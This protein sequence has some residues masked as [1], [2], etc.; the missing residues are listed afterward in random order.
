MQCT[1]SNGEPIILA[2]MNAPHSPSPL[3]SRRDGAARPDPR[4]HRSLQRRHES[5]EGQPRRRRLLRRQRQGAAARVRAARGKRAPEERPR[6]AAT[7]RSTAW[8][9]TTRRCRRWCS[10]TTAASG[11][12]HRHRAGARRHRRPARSAPTSSSVAQPGRRG[13]D[14]RPELGEP[15]RA[16]R[17]RRLHG[18]DLSVLRRRRRTASISPACC[19]ALEGAAGRRDRRAARLLPQP[20]RRRP[21]RRSNGSEVLEIVQRARPGARSSTSPTRASPTASTPTRYAARLFRRSAMS[22]VFVSSS[23]SKSFSLYGER[24]GALSVGHRERRR[25]GARAVAAEARRPHQLLQPADARRP[26]RRDRAR[27]AGAARAVGPASS[28]RMRER[29]KRDAPA[30]GRQDQDARAAARLRLRARSSA[31]CSPTR[32]SPRSRCAPARRILDLRHRHRPHL[33]RRA[34]HRATSTTSPTRSRRSSASYLQP[35]LRSNCP[36]S[37]RPIEVPIPGSSAVPMAALR[38]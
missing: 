10:A 23:F 36:P 1:V 24:V 14:Q 19:D 33:R 28:A 8:P 5:E 9:R 12:A 18:Q 30:A 27:H 22:P 31:A 34:Q 7:C 11:Q 16:V 29:I 4:R 6:R 37:V 26:G 17:G 13:L 25:G 3:A 38:R 15:P 21:H 2:R 32:A 20:D 35:E